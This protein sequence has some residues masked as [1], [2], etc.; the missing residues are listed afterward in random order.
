MVAIWEERDEDTNVKSCLLDLI[1]W[2]ENVDNDVV[3][4]V[5]GDP[6]DNLKATDKYRLRFSVYTRTPPLLLISNLFWRRRV[7]LLGET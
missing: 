6:D 7:L 2:C 3:D 1:G 5:N 4:P